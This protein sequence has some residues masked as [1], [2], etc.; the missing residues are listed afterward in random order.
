MAV[1]AHHHQID[2][3]LDRKRFENIAN[4]PALGRDLIECY[5]HA[6]PCQMFAQLCARPRLMQMLLV[7]DGDD[8][9]MLCSPQ[10]GQRIGDGSGRRPAVIPGHGDPF[11]DED[12]CRVAASGNSS[13]GRPDSK[14]SASTRDRWPWSS[15]LMGKTDRSRSLA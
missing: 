7:D 4:S 14:M 9:N 5:L 10:H 3:A 1:G 8:I 15:A 6:M 12:S 13:T 2:A 11:K